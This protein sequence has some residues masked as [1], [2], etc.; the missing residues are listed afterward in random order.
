MSAAAG[1]V[2][3]GL[4]GRVYF[5]K[6]HTGLRRAAFLAGLWSAAAMAW[7]SPDSQT[8]TFHAG[9]RLVQVEV[10]VRNK[11]A[12]VSGLTKD[13]FKILDQGKLQ[14]I[15]IFHAGRG[16]ETPATGATP[17]LP[18]PPGTVSN[19]FD[20]AG[21][22]LP[23][24]TLVLFDQLNTRFDLKAYEKQGF[25]HLI[26]GL[27][28]EE[29]VAIYVLGRNLHVLQ[30]FTDDPEKLLAAVAHVDSGRDLMPANI[31]DAM[32]DFPTDATG[33]IETFSSRMF[34]HRP[35][36]ADIRGE[37]AASIGESAA[38]NARV[39]A[40]QNDDITFEA[41]RQI[42]EHLSGIEGRRNL[43]WVKEDPTV[44]PGVMGMLLQ[45]DIALY[46]VQIR[47]VVFDN[48]NNGNR[49]M[50][51]YGAA[52][53]A[54]LSPGIG[55]PGASML[56]DIMQVQREG[57][58]LAAATG[59]A[60]FDDADD[61]QLAVKTAEEDSAGAY[62][63]GYYP[64]EQV[65]DGKYHELTVTVAGQK[66]AHLEVR[67]RPGY[68]A[69]KAQEPKAAAP[70]PNRLAAI[71]RNPLD[72]TGIGITA[73][74]RPDAQAGLY[75]LRVAVDLHNIHLERKNNRSVGRIEIGFLVGTNAL[76]RTLD[77][78]LSDAQ[79]AEALKTG[80]VTT[81]TGVPALADGIHVA[82]CDDYTGLAGSLRIPVHR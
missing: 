13:D 26:H 68:L 71:F 35:P 44:P 11:N 7:Q 3:P 14:H 5:R 30:D 65:L 4:T 6:L 12:P 62:T 28:P 17:A 32:M 46:P 9:T 47:T 77:L 36:S 27:R 25:L 73:Q 60:G 16:S 82:V 63:I 15:D 22:P 54:S 49:F 42:V 41:L 74:L 19:R 24:A 53:R 67:Y 40:L 45:A 79:L 39:S 31:A 18:L 34:S 8:A 72:V 55:A 59:G 48:P 29:R 81:A 37:I 21:K 1:T 2:V 64:P 75:Q 56:P 69:T 61:L 20:H 58:M 50:A 76:T 43:V 38:T 33:Q 23:S 52:S 51:A 78:D 66:S 57:R 70:E 10:V 80:Y